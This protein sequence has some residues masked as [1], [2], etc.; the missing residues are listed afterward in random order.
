MK[1]K[2]KLLSLLIMLTSSFISLAQN[3]LLDILDEEHK[4]GD[5][6]TSA[7]FKMTRIAFG[8]ST[9]TRKEGILEVFVANRFWNTSV[10]K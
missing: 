4:E 9:E 1:T 2:K 8:H 3:D 5:K 7:T 6:Y 10:K